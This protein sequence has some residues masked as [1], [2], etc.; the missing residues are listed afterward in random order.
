VWRDLT[1]L[2]SSIEIEAPRWSVWEV[3]TDPSYLPKLYMDAIT[4]KLEPPGRVTP[5]Q[6]CMILGKVGNMRVEVP[7]Q[8]TRVEPEVCLAHRSVPGGVF[9][10]WDQTVTL[11]AIGLRTAAR[12]EFEYELAPEYSSKVA[13]PQTW[14]RVVSDNLLRYLPR[15]KEVCELLSLP[16]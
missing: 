9:T 12:A 14:H 5:G 2:E 16:R 4:V 3:I 8:F 15:V 6:K 1:H 13:D 11:R 10:I 7:I